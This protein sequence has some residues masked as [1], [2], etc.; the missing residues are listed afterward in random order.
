MSVTPRECPWA[1]SMTRTSTF[2]SM[3]KWPVPGRPPDTDGRS[4]AQ[5]AQVVFGGGGYG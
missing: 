3:S 2:A 1:E 4:A 5:A